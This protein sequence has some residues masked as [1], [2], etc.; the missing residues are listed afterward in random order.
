[1]SSILKVNLNILASLVRNLHLL[2]TKLWIKDEVAVAAAHNKTGQFV[3][4][5]LS[6]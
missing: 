1:M 4:G 5:W 2:F 6:Y 3:L